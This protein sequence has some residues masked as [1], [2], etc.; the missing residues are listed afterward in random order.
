MA[1]LGKAVTCAGFAIEQLFT[2]PIEEYNC[3]R[4]L[5]LFLEEN[6]YNPANRG[7]Q[8]Y[9]LARKKA[10]LPVT[11]YPEFLYEP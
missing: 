8:S 11:R 9:C 3:Y 6:G 10:S 5:L 1:E 2:E 7:E 4:S